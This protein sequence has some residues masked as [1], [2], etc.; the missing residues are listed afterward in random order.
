MGQRMP[1]QLVQERDVSRARTALR[2]SDIY[3]IRQLHIDSTG[4]SMLLTGRVDTFYHKQMAQE[5]VRA[6]CDGVQLVNSVEVE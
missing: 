1:D 2:E 5:I 6:V 3:F 4:D